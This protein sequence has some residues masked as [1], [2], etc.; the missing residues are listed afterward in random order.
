MALYGFGRVGRAMATLLSRRTGVEVVAVISRSLAGQPAHQHVPGLP[1]HLIITSDAERMLAET[2]PQA[3]LLATAPRLADVSGQLILALQAGCDVLSTCEELV[4]PWVA[5]RD[6]AE[7][8]DRAARKTGVSL[9]SAGV[10][11]GFVF[12][13]LVLQALSSRWSPT[14]VTVSRVTDASS[15]GPAVRGR[16]G[17]GLEP[18]AFEAMAAAGSIAGHVGFRE[19]MDLVAAALGAEVETFEESLKPLIADRSEAGVA[20]GLTAGFTQVALGTCRGG[21]RFDF[22]LSLHLWPR[23]LGLE[24][25]DAVR[26]A[27]GGARYELEVR[28]ASLPVETAAAQ[29][30]NALPDVLAAE[31]GLRTRLDV[32]APTPWIS[33][34]QALD[35]RQ[36]G[37]AKH[38]ARVA[39]DPDAG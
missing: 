16:L 32:P 14:A 12:D 28:P 8:L 1:A 33:L 23:V 18:A 10:N 27:D 30:V 35:W 13:A 11:P 37:R 2:R 7:T 19:S 22:R 26:I 3:T 24:I 4:F 5:H 15:F 39:S 20:S 34:P 21:L 38:G 29:M 31:P 36:R 17:L 9:L 6:A 25:V